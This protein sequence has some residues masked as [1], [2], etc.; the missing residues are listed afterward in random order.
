MEANHFFAVYL[1][2]F[3]KFVPISFPNLKADSCSLGGPELRLVRAVR[4]RHSSK[5]FS[6]AVA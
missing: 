4:R 1:I 5:Q 3:L 6:T 2:M